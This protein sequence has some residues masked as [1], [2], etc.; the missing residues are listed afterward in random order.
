MHAS[1]ITRTGEP[2]DVE[3]V[4]RAPGAGTDWFLSDNGYVV[5]RYQSKGVVTMVYQ[6]RKVMEDHLGRPLLREESVHHKNGDRTDNRL[7]NLELWSSSQP[8]G[9][10]VADKLAWARWI[11]EQYG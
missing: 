11:I 6:H 5:K 4:R 3:S 9:Q 7:E 1:R 8:A 2:G 10:R